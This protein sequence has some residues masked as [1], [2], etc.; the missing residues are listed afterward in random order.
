D[1]PHAF[2]VANGTVAIHLAYLA[3]GLRAGD[4]VILPGFGY[5]AAANVALH[6]G[7]KPVFAE[8]DPHTWRVTADSIERVITARTPAVV[9]IRT[10]GNSCDMEPILA[11]CRPRGVVVIEDAAESF[12]TRY[13][14]RQSGSM[15]DLGCFS[16]QATKTI[17]TGEGGMVVTGRDDLVEALRL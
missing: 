8:V 17:T 10:Y 6:L 13:R 14:G 16:F 1:V 9:P 4:E 7:V 15:G 12:G 2:A 11:L 5:L 3:I